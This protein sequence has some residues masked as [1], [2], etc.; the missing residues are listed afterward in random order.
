MP[1]PEQRIRD[2]Y[3]FDFPDDFF[4]FRE[5]M[6]TLPRNAL[7]ACDLGP[8]FP[9]EVAAGRKPRDYPDRPY[10]EDRYYN[11]LPEFVTIFHGGMGGLHHGYFFDAPGELPPVC[12]FFWN[13]DSIEHEIS[14][15]TIFEAVRYQLER[16]ESG[17]HEMIEDD[18]DEA[19]HYRR[20][21]KKLARLRERL[22]EHFGADRPETGDDYTDLYCRTSTWRKPVAE[23]REMMDIVVPKGKYRKLKSDPFAGSDPKPTQA[24]IKPL[25]AEARKQLAAGY[26]GAALKLGRDLW[27]WAG[28]FPACYDLLDE[29]YAALGREPLRRLLAEAKAY[30][31][32]CDQG[33][34]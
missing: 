12:A 18:P 28:K 29:A 31:A 17:C 22:S 10:W 2:F 27:S 5:F 19:T 26:P 20:Q 15:D 9:F 11:D 8:A 21:L 13:S 33:R 23:T 3:G 14:G 25:V 32:F 6:A 30:R 1:T 34:E 7:E 16:E 4:R 24:I